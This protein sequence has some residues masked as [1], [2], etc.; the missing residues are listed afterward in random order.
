MSNHPAVLG[1]SIFLFRMI[2]WVSVCGFSPNLDIV[3]IWF[4]QWE[5]LHV[6]MGKFIQIL[7]EL[8]ARDTVIFSF[9][10]DNLSKC[11]GILTKFG[12]CIDIKEIWFLDC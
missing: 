8:S 12:T 7:K 1:L 3:E 5:A 9:Q 11:K 2:P 4:N 10:D 6:L